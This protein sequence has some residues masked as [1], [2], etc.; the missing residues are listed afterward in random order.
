M[1]EN[2]ILAV[3]VQVSL[4]KRSIAVSLSHCRG[5]VTFRNSLRNLYACC[6][7]VNIK[8]EGFSTSGGYCTASLRTRST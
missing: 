8:L 5:N 6:E 3:L 2:Q 7:I 1:G 4:G